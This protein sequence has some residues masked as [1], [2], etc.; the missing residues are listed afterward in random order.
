MSI[1][2]Y[3][4]TSEK[5]SAFEDLIKRIKENEKEII[6]KIEHKR[7]FRELNNIKIKMKDGDILVIGSLNSLGVSK[8][9]I[10]NELDYFV[11]KEKNLVV[12]NI[13]STYQY[14]VSQP[15]NKAIIKTILDSLAKEN[16]ILKLKE[17]K[18]SNAGRNKIEFPDN[19]EELYEK[20]D[21][22]EISSKKFLD[23]SGLKKATFYNMITEYKGILKANADF[24]DKYKLA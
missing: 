21:K 17:N 19:W 14:G 18:R 13:E 16:N 1:Y 12:A 5:K 20:W 15:M 11:E 4:K 6:V 23:E 10:V 8:L 24:V 7:N 22:G 9:D 2:I 3:S